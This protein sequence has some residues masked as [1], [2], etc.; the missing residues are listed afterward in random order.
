MGSKKVRDGYFAEILA[1]RITV[2]DGADESALDR[3]VRLEAQAL[4]FFEKITGKIV[5][6]VGF[7]ESDE[8][9]NV[10]CSPDGLIQNNGIYDEAV[11]IK[12]L[13]SA[14]HIKAWF[15][16]EVPEEHYGQVVQSFIVNEK[17][18]TLY[19]VLFDPRVTMKPMFVVEVKRED[20]I[21]DIKKYKEEELK[22]LEEVEVKLA[23]IVQV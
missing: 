21:E 17:L 7:T 6:T 15:S 13:S 22:F 8:N 5:E 9:P 20:I 14:N 1:E 16:N 12:C 11:E 23:E 4:E 3:G 19:F 18:K 2:D 10:A